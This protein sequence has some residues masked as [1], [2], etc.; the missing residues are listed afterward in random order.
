MSD[1]PHKPREK[2][3]VHT[4]TTLSPQ[5]YE[6]LARFAAYDKFIRVRAHDTKPCCAQMVNAKGEVQRVIEANAYD[7]QVRVDECDQCGVTVQVLSPTPMMIPDYVDDARDAADICRIINDDNL[8]TASKFPDR[9]RVL[10]ALPMRH[11]DAAMAELE[12]LRTLGV[13]GVEINSNIDG[14]D[15]DDPQF[16]AVFEAAAALDI[17]VFIHPW[18]G[19]MEPGKG[20]LGARMN[21]VTRW[22]PWL[23]GMGMETA[24]AFDALRGGGVHERLPDLRVMYAHGGGTFPALLGRLEHGAYCRPDLFDADFRKTPY[25]VVSDCGVYCD[26]LTHNPWV[27]RMLTDVIGVDRVALGTDYPYPLGEIDSFNAQT[28]RDVMDNECPYEERKGIYPGH[29]IEHLPHSAGGEKKAWAH[30]NWLPQAGR[31][32]PVYNAEEKDRML[33]GTAREWLG[34]AA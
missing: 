24:L 30:F 29:M 12:R 27:L 21:A 23:V 15:L 6:S 17:A 5:T 18:G 34:E 28:Y 10:G 4:H 22:R 1:W 31:K 16:F 7:G 14:R 3:D 13:R 32:L 9:F 19:F 33:A 8:L 26:T 20:R 2:W 11:A 25:E